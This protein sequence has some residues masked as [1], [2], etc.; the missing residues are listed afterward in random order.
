MSSTEWIKA[1]VSADHGGCVE[2]RRVDSM[3]EVRYSKNPTGPVL[4]F[5]TAEWTAWLDGAC[6]GEFDHLVG[7]V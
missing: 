7:D 1:S 3:I 2:M 6:R 5:T 4:R